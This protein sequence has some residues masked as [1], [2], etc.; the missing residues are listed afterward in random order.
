MNM[1]E[2]ISLIINLAIEITTT[3]K[4]HVFVNYFG[5]A[6]STFGLEITICSNAT[7][8]GCEISKTPIYLKA[9]SDTAANIATKLD[10]TIAKLKELRG[11]P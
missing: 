6:G 10:A 9:S 7:E 3:G 8:P 2:K 4:D 1:N 5:P 11:Q